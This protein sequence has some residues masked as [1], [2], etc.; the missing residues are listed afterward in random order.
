MKS[1]KEEDNSTSKL[2][3]EGKHEIYLFTLAAI[4]IGNIVGSNVCIFPAMMGSIARPALIIAII[5][6]A[7][8]TALLV[9]PYVE[10]WRHI[11]WA[12]RS[13]ICLRGYLSVVI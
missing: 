2:T 12:S 9:N 10:P 1:S 3:G 5:L 7:I 11:P 6:T 13:S 4:G 8:V